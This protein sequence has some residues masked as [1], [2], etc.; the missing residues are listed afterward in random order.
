VQETFSTKKKKDKLALKQCVPMWGLIRGSQIK[1]L[2]K[3]GD[4]LRELDQR[5]GEGNCN[6]RKTS[7]NH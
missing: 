1:P 3:K 5:G 4:L 2:R 7:E 6:L